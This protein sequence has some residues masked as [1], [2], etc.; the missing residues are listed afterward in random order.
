MRFCFFMTGS[1]GSPLQASLWRGLHD[2]GHTVSVFYNGRPRDYDFLVILNQSSHTVHYGYPEFPRYYTPVV[3]I[4]NAEYGYFSRLPHRHARFK[5]AFSDGSLTHDTKNLDQQKRLER[6]LEG[7]SF[8]YFIREMHPLVDYPKGY[9]PIDYPLTNTSWCHTRPNREQYIKRDLDLYISWGAS[10]PWRWNITNILRSMPI[11]SYIKVIEENGHPRLP[12]GAYFEGI[13]LAKCGVSYDGYGSNSFRMTEVLCR[14][15]LLQ[16][17]MNYR[18][19]HPL[20]DMETC[21]MF[22]VLGDGDDFVRSNVDEKL[23]WVLSNP[24]EAFKIYAAGYDHCMTH[25]T[26]TP[27]AKYFVDMVYAHDWGEVTE[28]H[29]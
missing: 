21:V 23:S 12:Q 13:E 16:G 1:G 8:P 9:Y 7:R 25:F 3:F 19:R 27:S 22:D 17:T 26:E 20:K 6:Y 15:L 18:M 10:H 4:D 11:K 5:N 28:I 2:N 14:T 29:L 24:E